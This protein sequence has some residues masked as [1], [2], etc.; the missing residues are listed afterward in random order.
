MSLGRAMLDDLKEP[1]PF[2]PC[3]CESGKHY[4]ACHKPLLRYYVYDHP[5]L[6][7]LWDVLA[8]SGGDALERFREAWVANTAPG[9]SH[10]HLSDS[11]FS[12]GRVRRADP[13]EE[14]G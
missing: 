9:G 2:A 13:D 6:F 8:Y 3:F 4:Q 10:A 1:P 7:D 12:S 14:L 11:V 5:N